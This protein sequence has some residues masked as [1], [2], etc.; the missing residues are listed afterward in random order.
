MLLRDFFPSPELRAFV[1]CYRIVHLEFDKSGPV[2]VKAYPPKPEQCLHFFLRDFF[3]IEKAGVEKTCQ[4]DILLIGQQTSVVRQ[5]TGR[6]F[7]DVQIVF[8][9][10]A[11]FRM[12]GVPAH[13][14]TNQHIDATCIFGNEIRFTLERL[15]E[16]KSYPALLSIAED[17]IR[18][19]ISKTKK[20]SFL[21][22][23]VSSKMIQYGRNN[24][25]DRLAEQACLCSKQFTR[26]FYERTG[27]N[28]KTFAKIIRFN[29][30]FNYKNKFPS[31]EWRGIAI[32]SGYCDYQH[33][34]KDY[35]DFTGL[36]P[37]EFHLLEKASPESVL[38]LSK[39]LYHARFRSVC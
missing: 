2:P 34:V 8:Q 21:V 28:P 22:D 9:P 26:K 15:Q 13:E 16:A 35:K 3:A 12:T 11:L 24:T 7:I 10:T 36:T 14:L 30:A 27:V 17:F 38:G 23:I 31:R 18:Q 32:E 20:E 1:Q 5:F 39:S 29:R 4:P 25:I 33:L 6:D 37:L 19:L